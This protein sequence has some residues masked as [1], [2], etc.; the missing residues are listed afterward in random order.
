M[1]ICRNKK[2]KN[3]LSDL[4]TKCLKC[5]KDQRTLFKRYPIITFFLII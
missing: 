4:A 1:K 5:G 2:C 3:E